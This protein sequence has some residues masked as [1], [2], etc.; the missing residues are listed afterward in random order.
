MRSLLKTFL[1]ILSLSLVLDAKEE[2]DLTNEDVFTQEE[3]AWINSHPQI[4][5]GADP[6]WV[7]FDYIDEK[8]EH[9]GIARDYLDEVSRISGL[10]FSLYSQKEWSLVMQDI[11]VS[12]LDLVPAVYDSKDRRKALNY[13]D[14]YLK[15]T[16]YIFTKKDESKIESPSDVNGKSIAA[17]EGYAVIAWIKEK[18]PEIKLVIKKNL[19]ECIEALSSGEV[20]GFVGDLPSTNHIMQKYFITNIK[21]NIIVPDRDPLNVYMATRKDYPLLASIIS[22]SFAQISRQKKEE[23]FSKYARSDIKDGL[24][25]AFGYGRPPYMYD[26]SS[27][28]GLEEALVR[29]AL[30]KRGFKL[31]EVRQVPSERGQ[32]ILLDTPEIDFSV[33]VNEDTEDGLFYSD[34]FIKY[35][36]VAITRKSDQIDISSLEDL[37]KH[38]VLALRGASKV[39]GDRFEQIFSSQSKPKTY[40]EIVDQRLQ[41]KQFFKKEAEVIIVDENIFKWYVNQYKNKYE[42]DQEYVI[43]KIFSEPTWVKVSFRD[44]RLRDEFNLGL[45]ELKKNGS[46]SELIESFLQIDLQK[47]LDLSKL[48]TSISAEY[49]FE[50]NMEGLK[51]VLQKF[52]GINIIRGLEVLSKAQESSILKLEKVSQKY[53][54]VDAFSWADLQLGMIKRLSYFNEDGNTIHVGQVRIYFSIKDINDIEISYIPK[55]EAFNSLSE[56]EYKNIASIYKNLGLRSEFTQLSVQEQK[57]I[58]DHPVIRFV[59]DPNWLPYEAFDKKGDYVGIVAEYLSEIEA[60]TG[61]EFKRIQTSSWEESV[62]MIKQKKSDMISETTDSKM[63]EYLHFTEP[64][65]QNHIVIVMQREE[66]YV[67]SLAQI[68]DKKIVILKD[69]G[70]ISKIKAAYP[71]LNF[72]EAEDISEGLSVVSSGQA[73]ALLCTMALGSYNINKG[74][75]INLRIVG[76]TEFS[77]SIGY[78]IQPELEPLVGIINKAMDIL[79]EGRKQEIIKKWILQKY[80]ERID[81]TLVWQILAATFV[82]ISLFWYWNRQMKKEMTLRKVAEDKLQEANVMMKDSIEFSSMIQQALLPTKEGFSK[83]CPDSFTLWKPRDI[84]GG[85]IYFIEQ[86]RHDKEILMMMID[87]TGHGVPGAFVTMLVKAIERNVVGYIKGSEEKVSP[88][89]IL[90]IF[91]RSMKHLLKQESKD[92]LSNAGFDAAIVYINKDENRFLYAGAEIPLFY[93]NQD[94]KIVYVKGDRHSI[95]YRTSRSEFV[96]KDHEFTL[97]KIKSFY[98]SSDGYIDQNGGDKGFPFGRKRFMKILQESK[99]I[100]MKEVQARLEDALVSYQGSY[101]RNDDIAI[102]GV[103]LAGLFD[104]HSLTPSKGVLLEFEGMI[105]QEKLCDFEQRVETV[106]NEREANSTLKSK[107]LSILT[108]QMQNVMSYARD[109]IDEGEGRCKSEGYVLLGFDESKKKYFVSTANKM[110]KDD[111]EP[112]ETKLQ[113]INR[114]N[115]KEL[116]EYYKELRK[117]GSNKHGRGAGLGFLEMA[118]KSSEVIEYNIKQIEDGDY[119]FEIRVYI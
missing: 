35:E 49:I 37:K 52:Q 81:Y 94:E 78:G 80:V 65:L 34:K 31:S 20:F 75:F 26:R 1:F 8:K 58:Q 53:K 4:H 29:R 115:E 41:H 14:S 19:F 118:K 107:V 45:S 51:K 33:G 38:R 101:D 12:K 103:Q 113:K 71:A 68:Q 60:V 86:L 76:K 42:A 28:K 11:K 69:Y 43:H 48:I 85:D 100:R 111:Q 104:K 36:N 89:K 22:K 105:T 39:L 92:A 116:K 59:G 50:N 112:L 64:Y 32:K 25:G 61:L 84:V 5:Y 63:R 13:T 24:R 54:E 15:L 46:Y 98:L 117:S 16:E 82:F 62:S 90:S 57:W 40:Q 95:G 21:A 119:I 70:Y 6:S 10:E 44:K 7:P 79:D 99:G 87:C 66:K 27:G 74:G 110:H 77:T 106:L 18:H 47:Q 109:K 55:L 9:R 96:F 56:E 72:I 67:D 114:L 93:L 3:R 2:L 97:D 108:E 30:L 83:I 73:D 17:V 23:I 88:A 91:N 102:I